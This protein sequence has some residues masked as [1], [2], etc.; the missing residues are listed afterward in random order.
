MNDLVID[1]FLMNLLY[2]SEIYNSLLYG[3][4]FFKFWLTHAWSNF[5]Y[6]SAFICWVL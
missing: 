6:D 5:F 1:V 4:D 3:G 2:Y